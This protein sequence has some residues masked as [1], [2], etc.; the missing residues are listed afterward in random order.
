MPK[1]LLS[2]PENRICAYCGA[3]YIATNGHTKYC[4]ECRTGGVKYKR[5][6]LVIKEKVYTQYEDKCGHC[7]FTDRRALQLDHVL[8]GGTKERKE[9]RWSNASV[10]SDALKHPEKYQLLC[11]NCNA[12]KRYEN[13]EIPNNVHYCNNSKRCAESGKS[14]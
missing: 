2:V 3:E 5:Y 7:G 4:L 11:A 10:Y 6:A 12:I 8:G 1:G 13:G 14:S 9:K